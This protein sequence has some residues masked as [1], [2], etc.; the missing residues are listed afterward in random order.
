MCPDTSPR[1]G[2][3]VAAAFVVSFFLTAI[4]PAQAYTPTVTSEG[5][6]VR[7]KDQAT[8]WL[9]GNA[10]NQSGLSEDAVFDSV[11]NSLRRWKT[12]SRGS[13]QFE[14][15][16]GTDPDIYFPGSSYD[17][18]STI[19]FAS[20][21][22]TDGSLSPGVLGLTQVWYDTE[23][24]EIL[25]TDI[26]LNDR[27]FRFTTHE[28][29][30]SG[31]GSGGASFT[32]G[33]SNV[34]VE[35][36]ITHE[37]GHALGLSHSAGMQS[38]MLSMESPEQA[39]LGCDD[40]TAIQALYPATSA[41][42]RGA[43][44]GRVVTERGTPV[45]G[46]HVV[47]IS[48]RRGTVMATALTDRSGAYRISALEAG[49]YYLLVE[50]F[51]PGG[52]T[53]PPY[54]SGM[55]LDQCSGKPFGRTALAESDGLTLR[56]LAV[57]PGSAASAPTV[58]VHCNGSGGAAVPGSQ[59]SARFGSAPSVFNGF[60]GK[61]GFGIADRFN[62]DGANYY[63]LQG[64]AGR[65]ELHVLSYSLYSPVRPVVS[66]L[67]SDGTVVDVPVQESVYEGESGFVNFDAA[68]LAE[69][70]PPGDYVLVVGSAPVDVSLYPGGP[71]SLDT[72][73]FL[74]VTASANEAPPALA[75]EHPV[76][77]RCRLE[78]VR[79]PYSSP[80][81]DPYRRK[82]QDGDGVGFCGTAESR[83]SGGAGPGA[84]AIA[85]WFLPYAAMGIF[86]QLLRRP[87]EV[88]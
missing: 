19:Y 50:P 29:D 70:L 9:A 53:L 84:G 65:L 18:L 4:T 24:G 6:S 78:E 48:R 33:K 76:N 72:V 13:M 28:R 44:A 14:Y 42:A 63:R 22:R 15:W 41:E 37:L 21:S 23:T 36:V 38:T 3:W 54:Y 46:A 12:A 16:Q 56:P 17:G 64:V 5:R 49:D 74:V 66:L 83:G 43:L 27:N 10:R 82:L 67:D 71:V 47:A 68:I 35:S 40:Q 1:K 87:R 58:T 30:T 2:R 62:Y 60:A 25:E 11:V 79:V 52:Q 31:Y 75:L 20:N 26:V 73:P 45:F 7:W 32:G 69:S 85:G 34:F 59:G 80:S 55:R 57:S 88:T 86:A 51:Y 39:H 61:R 77:A 8:L 81:R